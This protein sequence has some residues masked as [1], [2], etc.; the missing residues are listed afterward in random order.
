MREEV[1]KREP[2]SWSA[3]GELCVCG[4][5]RPLLRSP[6]AMHQRLVRTVAEGHGVG[7]GGNAPVLQDAEGA[8]HGACS[9]RSLVVG[10]E[11]QERVLPVPPCTN[12]PFRRRMKVADFPTFAAR[13]ERLVQASPLATRCVI[14]YDHTK[15]SLTVRVTDDATVREEG[16]RRES[17]SDRAAG[18]RGAPKPAPQLSLTAHAHRLP[19]HHSHRSSSSRPTSWR[20]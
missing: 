11:E 18:E 17:K 12:L 13:A 10:C 20:T 9:R 2:M 3:G 5:R 7:E 19:L 1:E 4:A 15:G 16:G 14:K 8:Q 6:R